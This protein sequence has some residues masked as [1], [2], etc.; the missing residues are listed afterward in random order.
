MDRRPGAAPA[1]ILVVV[2]AV[3]AVIAGKEL[4]RRR[5]PNPADP[6]AVQLQQALDQKRVVFALYHSTT[7]IPC[8]EMEKVAADVLPEFE[9]QVVFVDVNVYDERNLPLLRQM[10]IRVIPTSYVHDRR[11][12]HKV[13]QGVISRD[14]LRAELRAAL[15]N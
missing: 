1:V 5:A 9:G 13:F 10:N 15:S 11:G 7:C 6:P 4:L 3:V 2:F 12:N 14:V 8:K